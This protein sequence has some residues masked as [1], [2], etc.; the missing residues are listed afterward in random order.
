ML[1]KLGYHFFFTYW[2]GNWH[3]VFEYTLHFTIC[4]IPF[5]YRQVYQ[6]FQ[7]DRITQMYRIITYHDLQ[8]LLSSSPILP[9]LLV[10]QFAHPKTIIRSIALLKW[11]K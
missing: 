9:Q 8:W 1:N 5:G 4:H 6:E 3:P 2:I 7:L 11:V 10:E